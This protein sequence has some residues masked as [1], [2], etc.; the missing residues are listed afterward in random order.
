MTQAGVDFPVSCGHSSYFT[1]IRD[2]P[3]VC[4][5]YPISEIDEIQ[6][7]DLL[8]NCRTEIRGRE[9][10]CQVDFEDVA[11]GQISHCDIVVD[12]NGNELIL[13]G[14]NVNGSV[15]TKVKDIANLGEHHFGFISCS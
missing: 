14:G 5:A 12:G 9:N 3:G 7:G 2:N 15:D 6:V 10:D 4:Q 11:S 8:C 13:V 1:R